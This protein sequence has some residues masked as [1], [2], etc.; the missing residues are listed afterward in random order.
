[1]G[2]SGHV[3]AMSKGLS[4]V[5][6]HG[7]WPELAG[8]AVAGLPASGS[9]LGAWAAW[10]CAAP[11][12]AF[13]SGFG[14]GLGW[15]GAVCNPKGTIGRVMIDNVSARG[16]NAASKRGGAGGEGTALPGFPCAPVACGAG[17]VGGAVASGAGAACVG[18]GDA[19]GGVGATCGLACGDGGRGAAWMPAPAP[20]ANAM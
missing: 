17:D 1:M 10:A 2:A 3:P 16:G 20:G 13:G 19:C 9:V 14:L 4:G 12:R 11:A 15:P 7:N 6:S 5:T 18:A 8:S